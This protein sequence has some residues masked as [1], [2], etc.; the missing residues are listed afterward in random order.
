MTADTAKKPK[1]AAATRPAAAPAGDSADVAADAYSDQ[2]LAEVNSDLLPPMREFHQLDRRRRAQ[3]TRQL[4]DL[5]PRLEPL[6]AAVDSGADTEHLMKHNAADV[7]ELV[8]DVEDF[9]AIIAIDPDAFRIWAQ[10]ADDLQ[11]LAV[12]L[13]FVKTFDSGEAGSSSS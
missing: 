5:L 12:F 9:L 6:V 7:L 10:T 2:L 11:L 13:R 4:T 1:K 8:A 3:L